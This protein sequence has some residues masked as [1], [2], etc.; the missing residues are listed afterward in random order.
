MLT[1]IL[2]HNYT[3]PDCKAAWDCLNFIE[4][5]LEEY[6]I[7]NPEERVCIKE[8]SMVY[9]VRDNAMLCA[10]MNHSDDQTRTLYFGL[11]RMEYSDINAAEMNVISAAVANWLIQT[12]NERL[13]PY[14]TPLQRRI[15]IEKVVV[16][17]VVRAA[18]AAGYELCVDNREEEI[19]TDCTDYQTI[20]DALYTTDEEYLY[21]KEKGNPIA[22]G[23]IWF[24]YGN[25]GYDVIADN[26]VNLEELLRPITAFTDKLQE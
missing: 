1:P 22:I 23:Y 16:K 13:S 9:F 25:D 7:A 20:V 17:K 3:D 5:V 8:A 24:V 19:V 26:S 21:I 15:A 2:C 6:L 10:P 12:K 14:Q 4:G 11:N 18:L